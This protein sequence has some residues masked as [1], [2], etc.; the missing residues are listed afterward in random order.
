MVAYEKT[1]HDGWT[2]S[3]PHGRDRVVTIDIPGVHTVFWPAYVSRVGRAHYVMAWEDLHGNA[4]KTLWL[5]DRAW[6][7]RDKHGH[8]IH[9]E[10][11]H[12]EW[13]PHFAD[14]G[15]AVG[16]SARTVWLGKI[17]KKG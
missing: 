12:P 6:L 14:I 2:P 15:A 5:H 4:R 17:S 10:A 13:V 16:D 1:V 8:L 11:D 9:R 7:L 3:H